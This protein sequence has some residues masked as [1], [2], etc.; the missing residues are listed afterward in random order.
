M[1]IENWIASRLHK[2][3][4]R[5]AQKVLDRPLSTKQLIAA[6]VALRKDIQDRDWSGIWMAHAPDQAKQVDHTYHEVNSKPVSKQYENMLSSSSKVHDTMPEFKDKG[7][8]SKMVHQSGDDIFMT[9]P[10]HDQRHLPLA[11]FSIMTSHNLYHAGGLGHLVEDVSTHSINRLPHKGAV[12]VTVHQFAKNHTNAFKLPRGFTPPPEESSP[13]D[14]IETQ[15][16]GE[17]AIQNP[18]IVPSAEKTNVRVGEQN[19]PDDKTVMDTGLASSVGP[20]GLYENINNVNPS[21]AR[22]IGMMD[23]HY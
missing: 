20:G 9:K 7:I 1:S 12:Q 11:G 8:S 21:N 5:K 4:P 13:Q 16:H 23:S 14:D 18:P 2:A 17:D 15:A 3:K 10:Y 19:F 22:Q 6:E